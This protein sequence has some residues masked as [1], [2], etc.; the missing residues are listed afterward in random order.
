MLSSFKRY[1]QYFESA[2]IRKST[3]NNTIWR[4]Y[5]KMIIPFGPVT[6][7]Y[8]VQKSSVKRL[9][10][11]FPKSILCRYTLPLEMDSDKQSD[12]YAVI[13]K[14]FTPVDKLQ[15]KR[16]NEINR[17]LE[18]CRVVKF[19][20]H[21][22]HE[23]IYNVHV[24]ALK[25]YGESSN[26]LSKGVFFNELDQWMK[27]KDI[28]HY[29][30]VYY[31]D[32]L[33]AYAKIYIFDKTEASLSVVKFHPDFMHVYPSY[34]L[35]YKLSKFYIGGQN[36]EYINDGFCSIQHDTNIQN[37]LISKFQYEKYPLDLKI[38]FRPV[39]KF[40]FQFLKP[41]RFLLKYFN[42]NVE[43]VFILMDINNKKSNSHVR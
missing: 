34:A 33:V 4:E 11:Q 12:F 10:R 30:G 32:I 23:G 21:L 26:T 6:T 13:C 24:A 1:I 37:Y 16:R 5:K 19:A 25:K 17:G 7:N 40:I 43:A 39:Y 36:V 9:F 2:G 29:W 14:S 41:F 31:N 22:P 42:A 27:F 20:D 15:S 8:S 3:E 18:N 28:I 38:E 35:F